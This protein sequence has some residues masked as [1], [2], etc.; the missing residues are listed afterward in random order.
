MNKNFCLIIISTILFPIMLFSQIKITGRIVNKDNMPLENIEILMFNKDS[1]ALKSE[2]TNHDGEFAILT[3]KGDYSLGIRKFGVLLWK[4]KIELNQDL[5]LKII[6]VNDQEQNLSEVIVKGKKKLIERKIDRLVF[7]V[8]NSISIT[9]GDAFDALKVTPSLS[10]QKDRINMIGKSNLM[11]MIDDRLTQLTGDDLVNFLKTIKSDDI[12]NIELITNP[13][14]K[15]EAEGNSGLVNVKL[16]KAKPNSWSSSFRSSYKQSFYP[17]GSLGNGFNYQKNK[18]TV[19]TNINY[20]NGANYTQET[21]KIDYSTQNWNSGDDIKNHTNIVSGKIVVDYKI[22][23]KLTLGLQYSGGNSKPNINLRNLAILSDIYNNATNQRIETNLYDNKNNINHSVNIH[24]IYDIDTIGRK[25]NLDID[26]FNYQRKNN[27]VYSTNEYNSISNA[28]SFAST[29]NTGKQNIENYSVKIDVEHPLKWVNLNYGGKLS[30]TKTNSNIN[31]FNLS[32]GDPIFDSN[33]SNQF[34]YKENNQALYFSTTK[35]FANSKWEVQFGLRFENTLAIGYSFTINQQNKID[36]SKLFPTSYITYSPNE[37]NIFSI[38]YGKRINRPKYAI[39]NPFREYSNPYSYIEGNPFLQPSTTHNI[40]FDHTFKNNL[41]TSIYYSIENN[42]FGV[43]TFINNGSLN[44]VTTSLNYYKSESMGLN[45]SYVYNK[46]KGWESYN[47]ANL[48]YTKTVSND[49]SI[50]KVTEGFGAFISSNNSFI[51]N[52]SKTFLGSLDFYYVFPSTILNS[53]NKS[54]YSTDF[55]FKYLTL[56]KLLVL[57]ISFNDVFRT[58]KQRWSQK[59]NNINFY[60]TNYEDVRKITLSISYKLGNNKL[61][62]KE[63]KE[64]NSEEKGR[65]TN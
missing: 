50:E 6:K 2:L 4:K 44:Q 21:Q 40:S 10:V 64:S 22:N 28:N 27:Q 31:Y 29:N 63:T 38:N 37:N 32:S 9:G 65:A 18:T 11:I 20:T 33:K 49:L 62:N 7:N 34:E 55:G 19:T 36:Y 60:S 42:G 45:E 24:S 35:K 26:Y 51:F 5:N 3:G 48:S 56:N 17:T 41:N 54:E 61:K 53:K 30:F 47:S 59:I 57:N 1:I 25:V 13:P 43:I 58:S 14:A 8:E 16:K 46:Y 12:K 23:N 39:L 15:Y 52:E